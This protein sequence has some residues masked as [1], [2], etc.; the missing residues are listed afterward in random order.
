MHSATYTTSRISS[1][2]FFGLLSD[3]SPPQHHS[4]VYSILPFTTAQL[5]FVN[6]DSCEN[7]SNCLFSLWEIQCFWWDVFMHPCALARVPSCRYF[8]QRSTHISNGKPFNRGT[9][10]AFHFHEPQK[11]SGRISSLYKIYSLPRLH[12][13]APAAF[14]IYVS[15]LIRA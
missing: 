6:F 1:L 14:A 8:L 13:Y 2:R 12:A 3:S 4:A 7:F 10:L 15:P 11:V 5:F 9:A